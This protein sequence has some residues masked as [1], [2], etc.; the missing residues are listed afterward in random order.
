MDGFNSFDT[1]YKGIDTSN[2]PAPDYSPNNIP[3][4]IKRRSTWVRGKN[5]L[6]AMREALG[7]GLEI[8]GITAFNAEL[9]AQKTQYRQ[10]AVEDYN[11]QMIIEMTDKDV[12]SAP[13]LIEA[14]GSDSTLKERLD[15]DFDSRGVSIYKY[16]HLV[17]NRNSPDYLTQDWSDAIK[18]ACAEHN[19]LF[20]P[21]GI[22]AVDM[23]NEATRT[24]LYEFIDRKNIRL[25][26]TGAV[27]YDKTTHTGNYL[28]EIFRFVR[29]EDTYV[30]INYDA[31]PLINLHQDLGFIG[32]TFLYFEDGCVGITVDSTINNARYGIRAGH[33]SNPEY[34]W[35]KGFD[36]KLRTYKTGYPMATYLADDVKADIDADYVHRAGYFAGMTK[37][38]IDIKVKNNIMTTY[39]AILTNAIVVN[40]PN[41]M[42]QVA[43][44]IED[45]DIKVIDTGS[46][47]WLPH[48]ACI[49]ITMSWVAKSVFSDINA[50]Y[51]VKSSDGIAEQVGGFHIVSTVK[52]IQT[53]YEYNWEDFIELSN[54][55][56]SG[57]IDRSGQTKPTNIAGEIWIEAYDPDDPT[58][59]HAPKIRNLV[60][61]DIVMIRGATVSN[62]VRINVPNLQDTLRIENAKAPLINFDISTGKGEVQFINSEIQNLYSLH[63]INNLNFSDSKTREI[64]ANN[65]ANMTTNNYATAGMRQASK[66]RLVKVLTNGNTTYTLSNFFKSGVI[67]KAVIGVISGYTMGGSVYFGTAAE[68]Q[69]FGFQ[70]LNSVS[71]YTRIQP[72]AL[73]ENM[74]PRIFKTDTDLV[75]KFVPY[76][77]G[78]GAVPPSGQTLTLHVFEE[79]MLI[80]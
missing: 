21:D 6:I 76:L 80:P 41:Q 12:I 55:T 47:E 61:K 71:G 56:A 50:K 9:I 17:V 73:T 15:R 32:S 51:Y 54:I 78:G 72:S 44:G 26:G 5:K 48:L 77:A 20:F 57:T 35:S 46:T 40:S 30:D 74:F 24:C 65:I 52:A 28:S 33:Y 4:P 43:K 36:V 37:G 42:E 31:T 1:E 27:I 39:H 63:G 60:L 68:E 18:A 13:E 7:Q 25:T 45:V 53:A 2:T 34:G 14:R 66:Y 29:C 58:R 67:T 10:D 59:T 16:S 19:H 11:N 62:S 8:A 75:V 23:L 38:K 22:Y 64:S 3:E 70:S 79:E 69:K 49:G